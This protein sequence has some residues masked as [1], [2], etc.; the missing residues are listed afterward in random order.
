MYQQPLPTDSSPAGYPPAPPAYTPPA[1][2]PP[3]AFIPP[4]APPA[5]TRTDKSGPGLKTLLGVAV[6]S[7]V[8]GSGLT[9]GMF[10][11]GGGAFLSAAPT[12]APTGA[13]PT[14]AAPA[15]TTNQPSD[16]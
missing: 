4:A 5:P 3:P 10:E 15:S 12:A 2:T 7:A 8:L 14:N 1:Y 9:F 16:L 11:V 6:L 13:A